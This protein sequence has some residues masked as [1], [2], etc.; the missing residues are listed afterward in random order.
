MCGSECGCR[1]RSTHLVVINPPRIKCPLP[2]EDT[3]IRTHALRVY[4][5]CLEAWWRW[6]VKKWI[7]GKFMC[8]C[9]YFTCAPTPTEGKE[10]T[11]R[12]TSTTTLPSS[13]KHTHRDT[14]TKMRLH[15]QPLLYLPFICVYVSG[16]KGGEIPYVFIRPRECT[17]NE[18]NEEI[19]MMMLAYGCVVCVEKKEGRTNGVGLGPDF[20]T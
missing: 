20:L 2:C 6:S 1:Q 5:L 18:E 16:G 9:V 3:R 7:S 13:S 19:E 4:A 15:H 10:A 14:A 12:H 11:D 8:V 17:R